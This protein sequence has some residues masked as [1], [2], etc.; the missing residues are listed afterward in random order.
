[1][2]QSQEK[3]GQ[4]KNEKSFC[5]R[6]GVGKKEKRS[7]VPN[8]FSTSLRNPLPN[9]FVQIPLEFFPFLGYIWYL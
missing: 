6:D 9:F 2:I 1:M 4:L 5:K 7:Y 3:P 8:T